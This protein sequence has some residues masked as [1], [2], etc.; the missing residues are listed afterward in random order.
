MKYDTLSNSVHFC[1]F[2]CGAP[3]KKNQPFIMKIVIRETFYIRLFTKFTLLHYW[4]KACQFQQHD[5]TE[6]I[7][8]YAFVLNVLDLLI[9]YP[10]FFTHLSIG[11]IRNLVFI[12]LF[13]YKI[14]SNLKI[15]SHTLIFQKHRTKSH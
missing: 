4:K 2:K 8:S 15:H 13:I 7:Y 6:H 3:R 11:S 9:K 14:S 5:N 1:E 12:I 10:S